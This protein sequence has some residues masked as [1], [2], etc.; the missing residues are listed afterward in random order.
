MK[1]FQGL[2]RRVIS[3]CGPPGDG[4]F[5]S[6]APPRRFPVRWEAEIF[7]ASIQGSLQILHMGLTFAGIAVNHHQIAWEIDDGGCGL[8][9]GVNAGGL[10]AGGF[11]SA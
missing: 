1:N 9:G 2:D 11:G 8:L 7:I 10:S 5:R 3:G 6:R 4:N